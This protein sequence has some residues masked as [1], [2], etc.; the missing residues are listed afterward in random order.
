MI[1]GITLP[2]QSTTVTTN[3]NFI[4]EIDLV[5][6][7]IKKISHSTLDWEEHQEAILKEI[8]EIYPG[9]ELWRRWTVYYSSS[10]VESCMEVTACKSD[11]PEIF[12]NFVRAEKA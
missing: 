8:R 4:V 12:P 6:N 10:G 5:Q 2:E 7:A 9:I 3:N 1:N 11:L